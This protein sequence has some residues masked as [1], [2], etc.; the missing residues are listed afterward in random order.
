MLHHPGTQLFLNALRTDNIPWLFGCNHPESFLLENG[1]NVQLLVEPGEEPYE[2][3]DW[4]YPIF[5][6]EITQT[7]RNWLIKA[8]R[9]H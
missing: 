8:E 1:W 9:C 7:P 4:P 2:S 6:R 5:S 3:Q